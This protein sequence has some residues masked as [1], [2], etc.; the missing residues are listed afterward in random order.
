MNGNREDHHSFGKFITR[1]AFRYSRDPMRPP[2]HA[3][4]IESLEARVGIE[5]AS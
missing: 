1:Y 4:T 2:A 5:G 3:E